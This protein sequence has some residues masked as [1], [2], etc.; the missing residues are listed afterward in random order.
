MET[1]TKKNKSYL[2]LLLILTALLLAA[3]CMG[4]AAFF[5]DADRA[6]NT[7][8]IGNIQIILLEPEY[9][10]AG[11][12][13]RENIL[14]DIDVVKDPQIKNS[15]ENPA[16]VFLRVSVPKESVE[17]YDPEDISVKYSARETELFSY[18]KSDDWVLINSETGDDY[19]TYVYAYASSSEMTTLDSLETSP[20]LFKEIHY[21]PVIEGQIDGR[22]LHIQVQAYGI[23]V[24]SFPGSVSPKA[25]WDA[26][27]NEI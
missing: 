5:T 19:N 24:Q 3:G 25:A 18:E 2:K 17:L 16:Y 6:L 27:T 20:V 11:K 1:K 23:S 21:K 12:D 13:G 15:G 14:P 10:A 9:D 22:S 4:I 8:T 26:V 7:F